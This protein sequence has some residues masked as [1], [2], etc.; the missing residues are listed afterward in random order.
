MENLFEINFS[1]S[2]FKSSVLQQGLKHKYFY[3]LKGDDIYYKLLSPDPP[4]L[5]MCNINS[6]D[7]EEAITDYETNFKNKSIIKFNNYEEL[8][9]NQKVYTRFVE[10]TLQRNHVRFKTGNINSLKC[11]NLSEYSIS[12]LDGITCV[13]FSPSYGYWITGGYMR[14]CGGISENKEIICNVLFAPDTPYEWVFV[15]NII[16]TYNDFQLKHYNWI[17][18]SPAKNVKFYSQSTSRVRLEII[19][20]PNDEV[21]IEYYIKTYLY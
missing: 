3:T 8:S 7:N 14:V 12:Y 4:L 2:E 13:D 6:I 16:F 18:D 20:D 15:R 11:G 5:Y 1:Y 19:H 10:G 9:G 21:E 17:E